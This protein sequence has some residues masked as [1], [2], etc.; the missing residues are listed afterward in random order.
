MGFGE[1]MHGESRCWIRNTPPG[2]LG[3]FYRHIQSWGAWKTSESV[4]LD[5]CWVIAG[6]S[7]LETEGGD[8]GLWLLGTTSLKVWVLL[9]WF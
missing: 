6:V 7:V 5:V 1:T 3:V 2:T 9:K 4:G 8:A